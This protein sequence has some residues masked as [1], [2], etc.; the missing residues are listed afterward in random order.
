V[1]R[2][3]VRATGARPTSTGLLADDLWQLAAQVEPQLMDLANQELARYPDLRDDLLG[4]IRRI[5]AS[6]RAGLTSAKIDRVLDQFTQVH[7]HR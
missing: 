6:F 5:Y 7:P 2:E 1:D 4:R 3:V